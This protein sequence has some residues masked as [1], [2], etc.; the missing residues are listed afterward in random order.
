M[1]IQTERIRNRIR[2]SAR[3]NIRKAREALKE[4]RP[5]IARHHYTEARELRNESNRLLHS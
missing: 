4:C 5:R 1:N 2:A 3:D